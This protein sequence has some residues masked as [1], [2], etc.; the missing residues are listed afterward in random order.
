MEYNCTTPLL[1]L[2][3]KFNNTEAFNAGYS[4]LKG[5]AFKFDNYKS[6]QTLRFFTTEQRDNAVLQLAAAGLVEGSGFNLT[7][8]V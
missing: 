4:S 5:N 6:V 3:I 2:A 8:T 1:D 7:T